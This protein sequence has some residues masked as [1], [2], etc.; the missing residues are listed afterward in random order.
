MENVQRINLFRLWPSY[1]SEAL[2]NLCLRQEIYRMSLCILV[3]PG[4]KEVIKPS[5]SCKRY[6]ANMKSLPLS[7]VAQF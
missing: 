6:R 2:E 1:D 7:K 3:V 4:S 5:E